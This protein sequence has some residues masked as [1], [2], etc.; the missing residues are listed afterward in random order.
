MSHFRSDYAALMR[1]R[2]FRVTPQR[3]LILDAICEGSGHTTFDEIFARV[4]AK[5]DAVN[6]ATVYR[7]I[8]FLCEQRLVVAADVGEGH[9]V[10]E[11]AGDTPHHH[12]VCLRCRQVQQI[13][14][15]TVKDFYAKIEREQHF[16]VETDHLALFGL[17]ETCFAAEHLP[18]SHGHEAG[19]PAAAH[20]HPHPHSPP[21][22]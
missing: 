21:A 9:T 6:R 10:Y 22:A 7:T 12:L 16:H 14:H 4:Q 2:G 11:I 8:N 1:Q 20:P 13:S 15:E 18:G 5:S 19:E 17:C 3:Q